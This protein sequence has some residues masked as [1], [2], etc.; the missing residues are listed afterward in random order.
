MWKTLIGAIKM[1]LVLT[2]IT[3][4]LYPLGMTGL[5]QL[6]FPS[7]AN[8]SMLVQNGKLVGSKL[9][10]QNF[11]DPGYFHGRP[12]AA[13]ADGYDGSS[14]SGSNLGPTSQKLKDDVLERVRNERE[15]NQ[16]S[17]GD[18]VPSDLVLAS[19]SGLDPHITPDAAYMQVKRVAKARGISPEE[20]RIL[21]SEHI[22]GQQV[23][24]LGATR[25]NVL[26]LNMALDTLK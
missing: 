9:I 26:E 7:Q 6:L 18:R 14:S 2:I 13:G 11:S 24:F 4:V 1:L 10:G 15:Q 23:G 5:A 21:V 8:G 3:G 25:V 17:E 22:E 16:L 19:A 12:S 20:V